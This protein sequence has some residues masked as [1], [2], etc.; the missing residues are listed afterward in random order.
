MSA[1]PSITMSPGGAPDVLDDD[2]AA[3]LLPA[4]DP[5]GHKGTFGT[6]AVVAGS[7]AYAGAALLAGRAAMRAAAGVAILCVP[8]SIAPLVAGRVPELVVLALPERLTGEVD[9]GP[10]AEMVL[11]LVPDAL[12]VGPGLH[13]GQPTARLVERLRALPPGSPGTAPP[14]PCVLDAEALNQLARSPGRFDHP[15]RP[16]VLTPHPGEFERLFGS[17]PSDD[18]GERSRLATAAAGTSRAVVVLKGAESVVASPDGRA[19]I[20]PFALPVL[21]TAGS[22]DVLAGVIGSLLAQGLPPFEAACLGVY[23]HGLAGREMRER[24]GEAGVLASEIA[25]A[26]PG[27]R[28]YLS[29]RRGPHAREYDATRPEGAPTEG[30][31]AGGPAVRTRDGDV[32]A[33]SG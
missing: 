7:L 16:G 3:A 25:D 32:D 4:R 5:R 8:A 15:A 6:V 18:R 9:A 28:R 23:L 14:S 22:G 17:R 24:V 13:P 10:A 12:V 2:V 11:G 26:V 33:R 31:G 30:G 27:A 20:A 29:E 21:A 1:E 19:V